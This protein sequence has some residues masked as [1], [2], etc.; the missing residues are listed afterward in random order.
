VL[1]L[2][3]LALLGACS[4]PVRPDLPTAAPTSVA[5]R[6]PSDGRTLRDLGLSNGPVTAFSLPRTVVVSTNIDQPNGVTLVLSSPSPSTIAGYL[7]R[8]LP[9]AGFVVT[10]DNQATATL[11]FTGYG[12]H[13]SFTGTGDSSAVILRP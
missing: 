11:T 3:L 2:A 6:V 8:A 4:A 7:R 13:G 12:W 9:E 1:T 5:V 10:G